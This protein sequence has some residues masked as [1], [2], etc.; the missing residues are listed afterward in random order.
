M[1]Q[2]GGGSTFLEDY[3][4]TIT[5]FPLEVKRLCELMRS[6]DKE[7]DTVQRELSDAERKILGDA[8]RRQRES[9]STAADS[10]ARD[11]L[12]AKRQ[13]AAQLSDE[14]VQIAD[15][16]C[17]LTEIHLNNLNEELGKFE[18][19]LR[20]S[21]DFAVTN[22]APG[23]QVAAR[24]GEDE[25]ILARVLEYN[26][27]S[28][29]YLVCDEDDHNKTYSLPESQIVLLEGARLNRGEEVYAVYPDTTSFYPAIVTSAPRRGANSGGP[30]F[31]TVQFQDDA[32]ETGA[33]PD[34]SVPLRNV[35]K[36]PKAFEGL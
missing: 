13:R 20:T 6:L 19:F 18:E 5:N 9:A 24:D 17:D 22:A 7:A 31:C 27:N 32:D 33:T 29:L 34:R 4:E 8:K 25:W 26:I 16:V 10:S 23:E 11:D 3:L 2:A 1:A 15:Q 21:G 14:K 30:A 12:R 35:I 28:G 36:P